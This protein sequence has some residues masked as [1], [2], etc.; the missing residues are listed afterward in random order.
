MRGNHKPDEPAE[1]PEGVIN[2]SDPDSRVIRTQ[3]TPPRQTY[4]AQAVVNDKQIVLAAEVSI[5][6][7]HFRHLKP[8]LDTTIAGLHQQG[9]GQT[10]E[11]VLVDAGYGTPRRCERSKPR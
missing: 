6:A 9:I 8:M 5:S 7:P 3:G 1:L 4:N 2:L 11:V 10:P